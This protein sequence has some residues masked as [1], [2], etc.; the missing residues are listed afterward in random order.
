MEKY[1]ENLK[2]NLKKLISI[3]SVQSDAKEGKPFGEGAYRALNFT[4]SLAESLGFK[5]KNYDNYIG[6][7]EYGEGEEMAILCHLDVVPVGKL[8]SWKYP[9]FSA[10]EVDGKIYG[11]GATDDKGP[12][13][14]CLYCLKA[15]KDEGFKPKKKIKLIFGCN[16]ESGWG[17]IDHYN[18]VAKMPEFGF[19]PD[20]DFPV[21]YAEKG[22]LHVKFLFEN[23]GGL[24]SV[25]GGS[26]INVVCDRCD[27]I[28]P[29][30]ENKAEKFGVKKDGE[31]IFALGKTAHA[32]SPEKGINAIEKLVSYLESEGLITDK[33]KKYLFD[34]E[35]GLKKI[36]DETGHLTM[37]PNM[38]E[39]E[40]GKIAVSV[41]FRYPATKK[42]EDIEKIIEKIAP[43][44][45][46]SHHAPLFNDRES[47]LIKTLTSIYNE[48]TG[49]NL[50]PIAI[51]G[52]TYARALKCG[53]GFG[54]ETADEDF[55]IHQ[56]N[57]YVSLENLKFQFRIYK[58]AIKRL[59]E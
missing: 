44:E 58:K 4:L 50:A 43:Y 3:D 47:F 19:S 53:A 56:P 24:K 49:E 15:L 33:I 7:V 37:S 2:E 42:K 52:G 6:E 13:I 35:L 22:I 14:V 57:E 9:P 11:R 46:L 17:C 55:L 29:Y 54:P 48:E 21:I 31:T 41:D 26:A 38:I 10:T 40:N 28:A 51:G 45:I 1:F 16:E 23:I 8:S 59:S 18:K 25:S 32:S 34:D 5:T 30:N 20:A 36:N 39:M 27:A 12:A